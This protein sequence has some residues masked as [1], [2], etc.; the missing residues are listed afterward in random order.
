[1]SF[2]FFRFNTPILMWASR[3]YVYSKIEPRTN[4]TNE[5]LLAN[6]CLLENVPPSRKCLIRRFFLQIGERERVYNDTIII[7]AQ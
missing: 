3:V 2:G 7:A 5:L 4:Q 1:M 6:P